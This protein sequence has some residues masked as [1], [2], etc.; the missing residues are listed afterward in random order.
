MTSDDPAVTEEMSHLSMDPAPYWV[1]YRPYHL[2]S[3]E[4]PR[5]ITTAV[6]EHPVAAGEP[7]P[8]D[9]VELRPSTI[10][11]LRQLQDRLFA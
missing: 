3:I 5:T 10:C 8:R 6:V 9:A 2:A 1:L 4:A 11:H 7:I